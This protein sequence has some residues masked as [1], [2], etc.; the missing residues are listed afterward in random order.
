M[1]TQ[2]L[3]LAP[4]GPDISND[5]GG[6]LVFGKGARLRLEE[7]GGVIGDGSVPVPTLAA[8]VTLDGFGSGTEIILTMGAPKSG[9]FYRAR[10]TTD[11]ICTNTNTAA[12]VQVFLDTSIDGGTTWVNRQSNSH[13]VSAA[14]DLTTDVSG[15]RQVELNMESLAGSTLGVAADG[16]T[17][18]LKLRVRM[19]CPTN[20]AV[21]LYSP[22]TPAPGAANSA[23]TFHVQLEELF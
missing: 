6:G 16:T 4:S 21:E 20:P 2:A 14:T 9:L 11:V 15:A 23:G 5:A 8:T 19:A 18:S 10:A 3:R 1:E 12:E 7:N 13:H 22:S 17:A